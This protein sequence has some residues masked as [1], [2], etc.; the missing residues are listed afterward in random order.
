MR[1]QGIT[2][3]KKGGHEKYSFPVL[4]FSSIDSLSSIIEEIANNNK[5]NNVLRKF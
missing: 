4:H 5:E 2:A 1:Y 3:L